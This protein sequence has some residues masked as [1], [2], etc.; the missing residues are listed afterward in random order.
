MGLPIAAAP[1]GRPETSERGLGRRHSR[2]TGLDLDHE[3]EFFVDGVDLIG[4]ALQTNA[5]STS[6]TPLRITS[7]SPPAWIASSSSATSD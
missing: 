7:M 2:A 3:A 1:G 5:G 6:S 4:N